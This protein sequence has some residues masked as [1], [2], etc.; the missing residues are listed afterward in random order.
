MRLKEFIWD[1]KKD[2]KVTVECEHCGYT[3]EQTY[4]C[5][6][7]PCFSVVVPT[8]CEKCGKS[9]VGKEIQKNSYEQNN[10]DSE[11]MTKNSLLAEV[12]QEFEWK[13]W[14][15]NIPWIKFDRNWKVK[16][17]P[18]LLTG[19]VR[20]I[21]GHKKNHNATVSV[22]LDCYDLAGFFNEPYW[23][24]YPYQQDL[25]RCKMNDTGKLL[26]AIRKSMNEQLR[27]GA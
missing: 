10:F 6:G 7:A 17:I 15:T 16:V 14:A 9:R 21:I 22:Y 2:L 4:E 20:Y 11:I 18:P 13:K 25:F 19:I 26:K 27:E 1:G 3:R 8:Y 23:E 5:S 24:V 12:E